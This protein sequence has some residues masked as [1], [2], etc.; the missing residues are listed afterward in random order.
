MKRRKY[1]ILTIVIFSLLFLGFYNFKYLSFRYAISK[2]SSSKISDFKYYDGYKFEG[3]NFFLTEFK[4]DNSYCYGYQDYSYRL[5]IFYDFSH[6]HN[7]SGSCYSGSLDYENNSIYP[8]HEIQYDHNGNITKVGLKVFGMNTDKRYN[9]LVMKYVWGEELTI[10]ITD[11]PLF[12]FYKEITFPKEYQKQ[13]TDS[14][15][16][17]WDY[18]ER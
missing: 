1:V 5:G 3:K 12:F 18:V 7:Y 17:E 4:E 6:P 10:A 16:F 13:I 2:N 14:D 11:D 9:E 8:S 15:F